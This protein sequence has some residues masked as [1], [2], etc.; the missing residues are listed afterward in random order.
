MLK[1][2]EFWGHAIGFDRAG[3]DRQITIYKS[4]N[5]FDLVDEQLDRYPAHRSRKM[6]IDDVRA[7]LDL[8]FGIRDARFEVANLGTF[9]PP[10][11]KKLT[12]ASKPAARSR[13]SA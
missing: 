9:A 5:S 1:R 8:R 11:S 7:E 10:S 4:G 13:Y 2:S 12:L 3:K 6:S